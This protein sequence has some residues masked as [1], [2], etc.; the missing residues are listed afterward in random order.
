M[1]DITVPASL[2][3]TAA[4][5]VTANAAIEGKIVS[6]QCAML[7][8]DFDESLVPVDTYL[9]L[10]PANLNKNG[11]I[12]TGIKGFVTE[13]F[14]SSTVVITV[15]DSD[16]NTLATLTPATADD[17]GEV[18]TFGS[19]GFVAEWEALADNTDYTGHMAAAG[20]AVE[21]AIT[22]ATSVITGKLLVLVEFYMIP[23]KE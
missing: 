17:V 12:V 4:N 16:A 1:A 13:I 8:F 23:S 21:A 7:E 18:V 20:T 3:G 5:A 10:I 6:L 14:S 15:R 19:S 22:T 11:L 9:D 2:K